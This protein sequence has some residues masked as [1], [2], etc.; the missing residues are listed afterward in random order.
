MRAHLGIGTL[1][2]LS[3]WGQPIAGSFLMECGWSPYKRWDSGH[4]RRREMETGGIGPWM[5]V[6]LELQLTSGH[7]QKARAPE[8]VSASCHLGFTLL[9]S[10]TVRHQFLLF[11]RTSPWNCVIVALPKWGRKGWSR[12]KE[13]KK[14]RKVQG[15]SKCSKRFMRKSYSLKP[16]SGESS[17][18]PVL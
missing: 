13:G 3:T 12:M 2:I 9:A 14:G 18:C 17:L 11:K 15:S 8:K 5:E 10:K 1:E 4:C 7:H 16:T 6:E